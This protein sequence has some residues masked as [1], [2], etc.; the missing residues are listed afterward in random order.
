MSLRGGKII[1]ATGF[2]TRIVEV[3]VMRLSPILKVNALHYRATVLYISA[4]MGIKDLDYPECS[5]LEEIYIDADANPCL[6][7]SFMKQM[8]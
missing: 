8:T 6:K 1:V 5:L 3:P 7:A 4:T 2:Y